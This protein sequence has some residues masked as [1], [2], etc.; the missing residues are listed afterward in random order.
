[1]STTI[2]S[3][4]LV[5]GI[6]V[7]FHELGHFLAA[8]FLGV[9]VEK[10][11]LG[12]G[13]R[14]IGKTIGSTD[15]RVSA[16]PL[17]GY[18]KMVGEEE[19]SGETLPAEKIPF[20]FSHKPLIVRSAIVAAGPLFNLFLA[21]VIFFGFF[22]FQ[23]MPL[24]LPKIGGVGPHTPAQAAGLRAGD[25][26]AAVNGSSVESWEDMASLIGGSGGKT[27]DLEVVREGG[28][29]AL[30]VTPDKIQ[31]KNLF[32]EDIDRYV[33]GITASGDTMIRELTLFQAGGE[34]LS[35]TWWLCKLT[36]VSIGKIIQGT[37]SVRTLGGPIM[38][39]QMAGDQAK[40]GATH[41]LFFVALLSINLAVINLFP[42]P[43]LDGG[44][45]LFFG[46]EAIIRRPLNLRMREIA[47]QIGIALLVLLMLFVFYND[48]VRI[49]AS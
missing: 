20:S 39:A 42:I 14:L 41:L 27:V 4:I 18:V 25:V 32:G 40:A 17:G 28:R 11:S 12:F 26:V 33:I 49:F 19:G 29:V 22:L 7:F 3:F 6:L 45:L 15:Y 31:S 36:V 13:P 2:F 46:I 30:R 24:L 5:L 9:G 16:I 34:A 37:L 21:L 8:R 48:L 44:H 43:V 10:F 1:M 23:G 47:Q 35:Q 38:I